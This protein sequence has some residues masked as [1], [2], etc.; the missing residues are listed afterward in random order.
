MTART[1][2]PARK[3][4]RD[5]Y[6]ESVGRQAA[7]RAELEAAPL[8]AVL[9][10]LGR[11]VGSFTVTAMPLFDGL[12]LSAG[13]DA[14]DLDREFCYAVEYE[15]VRPGRPAFRCNGIGAQPF[16]TLHGA[17]VWALMGALAWVGAFRE[18]EGR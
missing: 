14:V 10:E 16:L 1:T 2:R 13:R 15:I 4:P 11:V 18:G 6:A 7:R 8:D 17:A 5:A 3:T 9:A 12:P